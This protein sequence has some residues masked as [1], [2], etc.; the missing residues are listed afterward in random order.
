MAL[1]SSRKTRTFKNEAYCR[2]T[3]Q[4]SFGCAQRTARVPRLRVSC[5]R[6]RR[7]SLGSFRRTKNPAWSWAFERRPSN[8][9]PVRIFPSK[10]LAIRSYYRARYYDSR[11]GRFLNED[12]ILFAG[13]INFYSY[14]SNNPVGRID[15]S[16]L[17]HQAW[18]EPPFDGRLHDDP[19]AGL[20]VLCTTGRNKQRDIWW[21][22]HS[23]AVRFVELVREGENAD[24]GHIGR[25]VN[26][27]ITLKRCQDSC[28]N[29]KKPEPEPAPD[30]VNDEN[31]WQILQRIW[32][33]MPFLPVIG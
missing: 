16:G 23:I 4:K 10:E 7:L 11:T 28:E 20:E 8:T 31:W 25:L 21:L 24:L 1:R 14:V 22:Q 30:N 13:N 19:G 18:N 32:K 15:P 17:I 26:E 27:G 12:P 6:L 2:D 3:H 5:G 9:S 33:Q 29:E